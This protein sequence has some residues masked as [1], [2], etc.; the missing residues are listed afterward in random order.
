M[1]LNEA[2][3]VFKTTD[4]SALLTAGDGEPF[5][6]LVD[7]EATLGYVVQ[8]DDKEDEDND[9]NLNVVVR[10]GD[11][12]FR[13]TGWAQIGSHCYGDYEPLWNELEEVRPVVK[14]VTEYKAV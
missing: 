4:W 11:Q 7:G 13:K 2:K 14:P 6:V 8:T 5:A 9:R 10:V 1:D 3:K 12:F